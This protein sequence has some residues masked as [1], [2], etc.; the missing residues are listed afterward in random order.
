[1]VDIDNLDERL[2]QNRLP[3]RLSNLWLDY[4]FAHYQ[5]ERI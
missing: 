1:M 2:S 3:E 4:L 5:I